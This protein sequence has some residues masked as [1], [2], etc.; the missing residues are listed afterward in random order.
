MALQQA[1]ATPPS[2]LPPRNT[3]SQAGPHLRCA[4]L[5]AQRAQRG[6]LQAHIQAV[7]VPVA[8]NAQLHNALRSTRQGG[9]RGRAG[10]HGCRTSCCFC[11]HGMPCQARAMPPKARA[12]VQLQ[13]EQQEYSRTAARQQQAAHLVDLPAL[14]HHLCQALQGG[15]AAA[16]HLAPRQRQLGLR[17]PR[18]RCDRRGGK[19]G[20]NRAEGRRSK[21]PWQKQLVGRAASWAASHPLTPTVPQ[22]RL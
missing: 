16:K 15:A 7:A 17:A 6:L 8:Q 20:V 14:A 12:A 1:P 10:G 18:R 4:D 9:V 13:R 11:G 3:S 2:I 5:A 21:H 19:G 22:L